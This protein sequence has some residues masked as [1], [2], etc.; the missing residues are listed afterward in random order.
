[1]DALDFNDGLIIP[2]VRNWS[3]EKYDYIQYYS[4]M[5]ATGMKN[6]WDCRVYI[7]IFAGAGGAK[8]EGTK[9]VV[10]ASPFLALE[11]PDPFDVYIFTESDQQRINALE[12]RVER[13]HPNK[14]VRFVPGDCNEIVETIVA[15]MPTPS[16]KNRVLSF[17]L[18]D[19]CKMTDFRFSTIECLSTRFVDFLVLIPSFM[20]INRNRK[21]YTDNQC[22][23]LDMYLG[24]NDWR[25]RWKRHPKTRD[26]FGFFVA[27]EFGNSM[28]RLGYLFDTSE[29]MILVRSSD[30]NL[31][32]YHL[33]FFSKSSRGIDFWRKARKS[34]SAQKDLFL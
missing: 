24:N 18:V 25:E 16:S 31:P 19:P 3:E 5:F 22:G 13:Y 1:M 4:R 9:R 23:Y 29:D 11:I 21:W 33:A 17:C 7:D 20:D 28:K 27:Q 26:S 10:P 2:E 6:K 34:A 15:Q 30:K 32:L 14:D 12:S 8:I